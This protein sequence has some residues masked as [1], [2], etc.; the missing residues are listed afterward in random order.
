MIKADC[1][2]YIKENKKMQDTFFFAL[3]APFDHLIQKA[4]KNASYYRSIKE[5]YIHPDFNEETG[6]NNIGVIK[7]LNPF[8]LGQD[9]QAACLIDIRLNVFLEKLY[10][11]G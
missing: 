6:D 7:L 5:I 9:I 10:S 1:A 4:R 8:I 11:A 2:S 3:A